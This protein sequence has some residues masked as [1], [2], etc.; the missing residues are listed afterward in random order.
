MEE[1]HCNIENY[2]GG[3]FYLVWDPLMM[4]TIVPILI[5]FG[6]VSN[7][8]CFIVVE[9]TPYLGFGSTPF[10]LRLMFIC[11]SIVLILSF[12]EH[13]INAIILNYE[14]I[15]SP[16]FFT[17]YNKVMKFT[18]PTSYFFHRYTVF[19]VLLMTFEQYII[20]YKP[21]KF[22]DLIRMKKISRISLICALSVLVLFTLP[23]YLEPVDEVVSEGNY[24]DG[25]GNISMESQKISYF[26]KNS[27][28]YTCYHLLY[29]FIIIILP[30]IWYATFENY[31]FCEFLITQ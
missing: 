17:L 13:T 23:E 8:I 29:L 16:G 15:F 4:Y 31:L 24:S 12:C 6:L 2:F 5:L 19:L 20:V 30:Y 18:V 21:F 27:I 22:F 10:L 9:K 1:M 3:S 14:S 28:M 11:E 26:Y 7:I 25:E